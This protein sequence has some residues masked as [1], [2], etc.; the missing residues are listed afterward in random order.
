MGKKRIVNSGYSNKLVLETLRA[1]KELKIYQR[2]I[3]LKTSFKSI[4]QAKMTMNIG[5]L[6]AAPKSWLETIGITLLFSIVFF[7]I[8]LNKLTNEI[9][10]ILV[11]FSFCA[12]R[13]L[14][15]VSRIVNHFSYLKYFSSTLELVYQEVYLLKKILPVKLVKKPDNKF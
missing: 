1:L 15:S 2:I 5:I 14:P 9:T 11:L 13:L 6:A 4:I 10:E 3:F 8:Y 12:V 7:Y